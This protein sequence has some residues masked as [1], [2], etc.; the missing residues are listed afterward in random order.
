LQPRAQFAV[1]AFWIFDL[2]LDFN[3]T[4]SNP[5]SDQPRHLETRNAQLFGDLPFQLL[6]DEIFP[7]NPC[8][9]QT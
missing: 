3:R 4:V 2:D 5:G 7:G 6:L 8:S 1:Y 9:E